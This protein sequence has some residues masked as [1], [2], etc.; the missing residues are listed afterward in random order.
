MMND[1]AIFSAGVARDLIQKKFN[2]LDIRPNK[3]QNIKIVFYFE[4]TKD[5]KEYLKENHSI[6]I[7]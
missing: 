4:N 7:R 1:V 2:L 5:L 6:F 3:K